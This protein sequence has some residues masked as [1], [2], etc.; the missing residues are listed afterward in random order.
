MAA[1]DLSASDNRASADLPRSAS[2]ADARHETENPMPGWQIRII[3]PP[4]LQEVFAV[5]VPDE[6][7]ALMVVARSRGADVQIFVDGELNDE[8]LSFLN[9]PPGEAR[10]I[11]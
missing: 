6:G 7:E 9:V 3:I 1:L 11:V 2:L 5:N 10:P 8:T 4:D